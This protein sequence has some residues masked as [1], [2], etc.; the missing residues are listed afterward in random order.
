MYWDMFTVTG[1]VVGAALT[2][3]IL[4]AASVDTRQTKS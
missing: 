4:W 1:L 2:V 3:A